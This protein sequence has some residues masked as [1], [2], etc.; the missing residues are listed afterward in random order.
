MS[1]F[2]KARAAFNSVNPNFWYSRYVEYYE[3]AR[4]LHSENE[5]LRERLYA[6]EERLRDADFM[7]WVAHGGSSDI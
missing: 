1:I 5:E 6:A 3:D 2:G 7:S 4:R